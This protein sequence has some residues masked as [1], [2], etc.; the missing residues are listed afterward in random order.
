MMDKHPWTSH[1]ASS[2]ARH[3]QEHWCLHTEQLGVRGHKGG[4]G[5]YRNQA[6]S[7][8]NQANH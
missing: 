4:D 1:R 5:V 2:E 8:L 7:S 6:P 3:F